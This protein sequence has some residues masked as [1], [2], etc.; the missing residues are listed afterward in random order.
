MCGRVQI[1]RLS[2]THFRVKLE[3]ST[4]FWNGQ[5]AGGPR[6]LTCSSKLG[7]AVSQTIFGMLYRAPETRRRRHQREMVPATPVSSALDH[8]STC[9][10]GHP[11]PSLIACGRP[12]RWPRRK[13]GHGRCPTASGLGAHRWVRPH[14]RL[15]IHTRREVPTNGR[16]QWQVLGRRRHPMAATLAW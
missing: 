4:P 12:P 10:R 15:R 1:G 5:P 16:S 11:T 9:C 3:K 8:N 7:R 2:F 14:T 6:R 13:A